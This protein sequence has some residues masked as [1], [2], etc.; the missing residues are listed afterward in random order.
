[1]GYLY[2]TVSAQQ[3]IF[4]PKSATMGPVVR[5]TLKLAVTLGA[6]FPGHQLFRMVTY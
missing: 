4:G 6:D 3:Y 2:Q 1:M 5:T